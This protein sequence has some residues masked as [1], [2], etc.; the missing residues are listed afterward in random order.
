MFFSLF[1]RVITKRV[2][3]CYT[4]EEEKDIFVVVSEKRHEGSCENKR[5][6]LNIIT[7]RKKT[8]GVLLE[9]MIILANK[10]YP[11]YVQNIC[12]RT[13]SNHQSTINKYT[14]K[15]ML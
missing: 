4:I 13:L 9:T 8:V 1:L 12:R 5:E 7:F 6:R 3:N 15:H 11:E 10:H 14:N 2:N